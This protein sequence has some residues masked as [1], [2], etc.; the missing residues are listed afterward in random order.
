MVTPEGKSQRDRKWR[1]EGSRENNNNIS[2]DLSLFVKSGR[3]TRYE[4]LASA[5]QMQNIN[6]KTGNKS[7]RI[8]VS[9]KYFKKIY[10]MLI[11]V[12]KDT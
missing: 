1:R 11:Y 12:K 8:K 2:C 3:I 5:F 4:C 7:G 9:K 6:S 10:V